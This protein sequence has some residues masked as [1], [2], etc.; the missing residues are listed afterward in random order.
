MN[1]EDH[2]PVSI[3]D[4][5]RGFAG[6]MHLYAFI[7]LLLGI[8]ALCV[9]CPAGAVY[10]IGRLAPGDATD[11]G[12][13]TTPHYRPDEDTPAWLRPYVGSFD[14]HGQA[15]EISPRG[16][17]V[18]HS[19][20]YTSC[21]ED[22]QEPCERFPGDMPLRTDFTV[23]PAGDGVVARDGRRDLPLRVVKPGIVEYDSL[24]FCDSEVV[25]VGDPAAEACGA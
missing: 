6:M 16:R 22:P 21:D 4:M 14:R 25:V 5:V 18:F 3:I 2:R 11:D 19:R 13:Q 10:L 1:G 20:T 15:L 7:G 8:F 24:T 9:G 17:G 23:E 12:A